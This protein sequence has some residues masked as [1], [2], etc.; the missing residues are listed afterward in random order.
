MGAGLTPRWEG[1]GR[2][3]MKHGELRHATPPLSRDD[4]PL[5]QRFGLLEVGSVK[6]LGEPAVNRGQ[7]GVGFPPLALRKPEAAQARGRAQLPGFGLL[8]AGQSQGLLEAGFGPRRIW[9]G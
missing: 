7:Q 8:A 4:L 9:D 6:A 1:Y 2:W 3:N 5:Q